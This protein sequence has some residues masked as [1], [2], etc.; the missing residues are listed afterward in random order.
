[1]NSFQAVMGVLNR[2]KPVLVKIIPVSF[3]RR[4]KRV[5]M[6]RK[7]DALKREPVIPF[8]RGHYEDGVNLIGA[9]RG[10]FGLGQSCR[11]VAWELQA[12]RI[13]FGVY[14]HCIT[15]RFHMTDH[16]CDEFLMAEPRYNVNLLH[17]NANEFTLAYYQLG[18]Q[19]FDYRYNIAFWLWELEDFPQEWVGCMD[20]LDEIWTPSE[21]VSTAIRKKTNKP[22]VTIPYHVEA[23]VD[24]QQF[25]RAYFGL[26]QDRFLYLM[27]YD[28]NS[29]L[30]RKNP[31]G[32]LRAFK[33]AFSR[34]DRR[35]GLVIK[36][37]GKNKE[38]MDRIMQF[39]D[40][41]TNVYFMTEVLT[42][43]QVN[44]LVAAVDVY[45]SMHR[46]EG[47]GLVMAEAMQNGTP[48][49]ATNWSAN[50]EFM[51]PEVAC[52]LDYQLIPITK[53]IGPFQKGNHWADPDVHQA[54]GY[55]R[56]LYEDR[57]YYQE[58]SEQ[59]RAYAVEVFDGK[60][61]AGMVRR[62]FEEICQGIP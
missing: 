43:I 9:I 61:I 27:M 37:N 3:L 15:E 36:L 31:I 38:D 34:D 47:F 29:M 17:I 53:D 41:Y 51:N 62:R 44:S 4:V 28:S 6:R 12:S 8:D 39:L 2:C 46:A 57:A 19:I 26:P 48:C 30:E 7:T 1:M 20:V 56:R 50:T 58:I 40:G 35:V 42:K 49:I 10:D 45:V 22:V 16:S 23:P 5:Y 25:D 21:F 54:A 14:E 60:R 11:L 13:P 55:M 32:V 18:R 24:R 52:M 33:E 59:A